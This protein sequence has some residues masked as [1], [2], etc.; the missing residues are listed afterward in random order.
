VPLLEARLTGDEAGELFAAME[1][2]AHEV[3]AQLAHEV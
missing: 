2:A 3:K 1:H